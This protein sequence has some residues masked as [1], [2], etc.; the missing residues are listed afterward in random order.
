[1][2]RAKRYYIPGHVWHLTHRCHE[3][4][5]LLKFS[6]DRR[7]WL[8]WLYEAKR[9]YALTILNYMVTSNHLLIHTPKGNLSRSMRHI[10][11]VYT[12]RFNRAHGLDGALFRGRFKSILVDGDEYLL[13]LVRYIHR[14]S[15]RAGV[16]NHLHEY[17][18][19]SHKG[20]LSSAKKWEWLHKGF[21]LSILSS[22]KTGQ[23]KARSSGSW[24]FGFGS[25]IRGNQKGGLFVLQRR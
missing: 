24:I 25:W 8:Q 21:I 15:V 23:K 14:N 12:Q 6:K 18:W 22:T 9:R 3:K 11:G 17:P 16:A 10:N 1:M 5:F 19:S 13:G 4:E 7:R 20:Y 2:A